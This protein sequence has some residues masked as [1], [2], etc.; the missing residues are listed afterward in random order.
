MEEDNERLKGLK[1]E[2][3]WQRGGGGKGDGGE[4]SSILL[5]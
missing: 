3:K 1:A 2:V 5:D 4:R